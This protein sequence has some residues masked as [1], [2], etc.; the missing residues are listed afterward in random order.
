MQPL[1]R[2]CTP[3]QT[4]THYHSINSCKRANVTEYTRT[5]AAVGA[6]PLPAATTGVGCYALST[7]HAPHGIADWNGAVEAGVALRAL[8][9]VRPYALT[10]VVATE[11]A[12]GRGTCRHH[13][14]HKATSCKAR[15]KKCQQHT[16]DIQSAPPHPGLHAHKLLATHEPPLAQ[17]L[18]PNPNAA[19]SE[20]HVLLS[21]PLHVS[22]TAAHGGTQFTIEQ[23]A[24]A[25]LLMHEQ[26]F[27]DTHYNSTPQIRTAGR[28]LHE[29][30]LFFRDE[31]L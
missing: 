3:L 5:Y 6:G 31:E 15:A 29:N 20:T 21:A 22:P 10:T 26:L 9:Q 11:G 28:S 23:S 19:H 17:P 2:R 14:I 24:P 25:Q 7:V 16:K 13:T 1:H 30:I 12:H 8:T 27:G 4:A 18:V